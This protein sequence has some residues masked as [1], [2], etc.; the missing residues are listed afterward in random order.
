VSEGRGTDRPLRTVGAPWL[1]D[2]PDAARE[3]NALG[4]PG[5][6]FAAARR[7]VRAGE[8]FGGRTIPMLD[9]LVTDRD[10]VEPVATGAQLLRVVQRRHPARVR[11]QARGLEE[12][13][14][15]RALREAITAPGGAEVARARTDALVRTWADEAAAFQRA[16]RSYWLYPP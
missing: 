2:A 16:T 15:S 10:A 12:L 1:D 6:R 3:L 14:G 11:Y 4:L 7:A 5:V 8:K 9:V 13:A